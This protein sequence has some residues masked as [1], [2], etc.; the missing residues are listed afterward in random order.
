MTAKS[1]KRKHLE[2]SPA[3]P[4]RKEAIASASEGRI[5]RETEKSIAYYAQHLD[6]ID[7]RLRDLDGEWDIERTLETAASSL[8]LSGIFLSLTRNKKWLLL[9][10]AVQGFF[11]QHALQGWCPPLPVLR[12][13]GVRTADEINQERFA[14]KALRGDF[15]DVAKPEPGTPRSG[16]V[17]QAVQT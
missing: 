16:Q 15:K 6:K 8:T 10:L 3:A 11:M 4:G 9:S 14:L 2:Q 13:F 17:Y 12:R 7:E 5:K 1:A